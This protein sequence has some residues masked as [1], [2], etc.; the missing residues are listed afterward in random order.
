MLKARMALAS[1]R[2]DGMLGLLIVVG[3]EAVAKAK[4]GQF[5]QHG[6]FCHGIH[7]LA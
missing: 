7:A 1:S 6:R 5:Y 4:I 2:R 3:V